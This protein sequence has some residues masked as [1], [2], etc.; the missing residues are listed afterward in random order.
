MS[1][2]LAAL[3]ATAVAV[4]LFAERVRVVVAVEVPEVSTLAAESLRAQVIDSLATATNVVPWGRG[5]AFAA[6]VERGE[7]DLLRHDPR[8]LAVS[9]DEGGEGALLQSLPLVGINAVRAQGLDGRGVTVAVL[10]TGIDVNHAD[11]AGRVVAQQCFC[12]NGDGSGCCPSGV[13]KQSGNGAAAD[14]HGHGTHVAGIIAGGGAAAPAGVAPAAQLVAVKVMDAQNRFRS[15][16]QIYQALEWIALHRPDVR[17]INMSLGSHGTY[18]TRDCSMAAM[19]HGLADVIA[20]LRARGV[21]IAA[22]SGNQGSLTG[23]TLPACMADVLG[24]GAT[25]DSSGDFTA[26]CPAPGAHADQVTCFT[27]STDAIDLVAPGSPISASRRGG[28]SIGYSGTSM[29]A[30]HVAGALALMQQ[31]SGGKLTADQ[32][33][34]ILESTGKRVVD[35]RNALAFPRLDLAAA[36]AATP[37]PVSGPRRRSVKK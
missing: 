6:E 19:A 33:E 24:V 26:F 9:I 8:V 11:F 18:A 12:D 3:L 37:R 5:R 14:D 21:L 34:Q 1:R 4:P 16:T 7:L 31:A 28:G 20:T 13:T 10:D 35:L 25:Y 15:F 23:V 30:P 27:N 32:S 29:A 17:V 2:F 22:S 36:I